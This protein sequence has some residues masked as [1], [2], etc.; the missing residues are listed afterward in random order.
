MECETEEG[1]IFDVS[2][3]MEVENFEEVR[4]MD[5]QVE[6]HRIKILATTKCE[7]SFEHIQD[8]V[9]VKDEA[10]GVFQ[11]N[12]FSIK[13]EDLEIP[14]LTRDMRTQSQPNRVSNSVIPRRS[15]S[16]F[17]V[18][19]TENIKGS[20]EGSDSSISPIVIPPMWSVV[21]IPNEEKQF[22]IFTYTRI[23]IRNNLNCP[24][25]DRHITL[26]VNKKLNYFVHGHPLNPTE[27]GFQNILS[28]NRELPNILRRFQNMNLCGGLGKIDNHFLNSN[29]AFEDSFG[30]RHS[31]DCS[32]FSK[33]KRCNYC[34]TLRKSQLQR[35]LRFARKQSL[36]KF[37]NR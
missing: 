6:N 14:C 30:E 18:T 34:K 11:S 36:V 35:G 10:E 23:L 33:Q 28:N 26:D 3:C 15:L 24:I 13:I 21:N 25:N 20:H 9:S 29:I 19:A 4:T 32:L 17:S 12:E 8:A 5:S 7:E 16:P 37:K 27:K 22:F 1:T 2:P 31:N